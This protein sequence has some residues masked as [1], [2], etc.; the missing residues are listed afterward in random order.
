ML[1]QTLIAENV[2]EVKVEFSN[3]WLDAYDIN[4]EAFLVAS[5]ATLH[6]AL[7]IRPSVSQSVRRSVCWSVRLTLLFRRLWGIWLYCSCQNAPLTFN[8]A[9]AHPHATRVA[10]YTALF[11]SLS[12]F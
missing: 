4:E 9:P 12:V 6:P 3:E 8:I 2:K 1:K 7:S 5:Y 11:F 10:M